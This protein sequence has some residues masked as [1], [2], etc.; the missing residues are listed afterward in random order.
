M[1]ASHIR[2]TTRYSEPGL[3]EITPLLPPRPSLPEA[4]P[5]AP[6]MIYVQKKVQWEYKQLVRNLSK[7]TTLTADELNTLGQEGWELTGVTTDAPFVY[8]YF[9][10]LT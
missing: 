7:E 8:F 5:V 3:L 2:S 9:K 10:R 1:I 6:P 4:P